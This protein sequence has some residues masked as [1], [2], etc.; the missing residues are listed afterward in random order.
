LTNGGSIESKCKAN[1]SHS[2]HN[3]NTV[4]KC[5]IFSNKK[6]LLTQNV[7]GNLHVW[8]L[9]TGN[10]IRKYDKQNFESLYKDLNGLDN[11]NNPEWCNVS[12]HMGFPCIEVKDGYNAMSRKDA[13]MTEEIIK[14]NLLSET[15]IKFT[16]EVGKFIK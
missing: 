9:R 1:A 4:I 3:L 6:F 15:N 13:N 11:D 8:D 5:K 14:Y 10:C 16:N 12:I 2:I 7:N